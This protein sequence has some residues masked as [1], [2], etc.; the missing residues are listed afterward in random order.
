MSPKFISHN[1]KIVVGV[2]IRSRK[3]YSWDFDCPSSL[4]KF[5]AGAFIEAIFQS[6]ILPIHYNHQSENGTT[7]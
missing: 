5:L 3:I 6:I 4:Q 2:S 7:K 1:I